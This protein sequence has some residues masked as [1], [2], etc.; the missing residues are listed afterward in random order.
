MNDSL[1]SELISALRCLPGV[2]PRSA[3]RM[4]FHL[5]QRD[6]SGGAR[7]GEVMQQAMADIQHCRTCRRFTESDQC[8]ICSDSERDVQQ[9]CVVETAADVLALEAATGFRGRYFV[10][11]GHLS[12]IDGIGPT[13]L[14]LDLLEQQLIANSVQELTL[15]TNPTV[16]GSA[17]AAYI[18]D[19]AR[20]HDVRVLQIARGVPMGGELEF[21]DGGTLSV[22]FADRTEV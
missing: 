12:P 7:L 13:E 21:T 8:A 4:A 18:G 2:G 22:A 14:G 1:L 11:M 17:T 9:L 5:L 3:Q 6:R 16:E 20:R 15:A 10:L 19:M